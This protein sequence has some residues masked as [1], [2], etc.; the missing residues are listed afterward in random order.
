MGFKFLKQ[1]KDNPDSKIHTAENV[2][3]KK[4]V[5]ID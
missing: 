4:G 1:Q 5:K 3:V 2:I